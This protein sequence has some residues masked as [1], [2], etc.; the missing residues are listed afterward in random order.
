MTGSD[1]AHRTGKVL[2]IGWDAADWKVIRPLMEQGHM[3]AL[4]RVMRE[5]V[6]GN[7]ATMRPILSPMLWTSIGTG[8]RPTKHG[9]YGFTEPMPDGQGVRPSTSTTRTTKAI[10]NITTQ[11]AMRTHAVGWFCSHPAEPINGVCVS[12]RFDRVTTMKPEEWIVPDGA[13]YPTELTKTLSELRLHPSELTGDLVLPFIPNA[14]NIDQDTDRRLTM[15]AKLFCE[16]V[17]IHSAA[18]WIMEHRPWDFMTVY[19]PAIDHFCHGFMQYHPPRMP[20]VREADFEIYKDV[21]NG[22]YRFH[23]MMLARM[24][25][26]AGDDVTVVIC[27]DHGFHSDHL[28]PPATPAE[29]AGPAVWHREYGILCMRGPRIRKGERVYGASVLDITPTILTL[30]G[31]PVGADMDGKPLLSVLE[32]ADG[33]LPHFPARVDSWD[34]VEGEAGMH[35]ADKREDPFE[36]REAL[37]QLIDLGYIDKPDENAERAAERAT[38]EA[39]FNL[40]R[41]HLDGGET[42]AATTLLEELWGQEPQETRYGFNLALAYL[43]GRRHADARL[44]VEQVLTSLQQQA[45]RT[46]DGLDEQRK[47]LRKRADDDEKLTEN[48]DAVERRITAVQHRL[49]EHDVR[50]MPRVRFLMGVLDLADRNAEDAL[51]HLREAER[52][53]PRMPGLHVQIGRAY[54]VMKRAEDALR[55]FDKA[56]EIDGDSPRAHDGRAA[57]L[58]RL[59]QPREAADHAIT[60]VDLLPHFPQAHFHLGVALSR[61]GMVE[62]AIEA[63]EACVRIAPNAIPPNRHLAR[64][65]RQLE[66]S[67]L[68][69]HYL[70]RIDYIRRA[71]RRRREQVGAL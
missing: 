59:K 3:P 63:F 46:A 5:G 4:Q 50:L 41:A 54:L 42:E 30:L 55:A 18:T 69:A 31:L 32:S 9:V 19:N 56:L 45:G 53:E 20:N 12:E 37:Q 33:E 38:R 21:I 34:A 57:A 70:N 27:S 47:Q 22:C 25:Q 7:L 8:K 15:F 67:D 1:A 64:I 24:M 65:Y 14:A 66:R 52:A 29:P 11:H 2:L 68:A 60:A 35:P 61:L 26:L 39:Q 28:R 40:A 62:R 6:W 71:R 51:D 58:L 36:A 16:M 13:V 44:T 43:A 10:W 17:N 49:R 48:L 23:D